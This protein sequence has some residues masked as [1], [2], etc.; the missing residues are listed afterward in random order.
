MLVAGQTTP[1]PGGGK[2]LEKMRFI[3]GDRASSICDGKRIN[4]GEIAEALH[5]L[6]ATESAV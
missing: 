5:Q 2:L 4:V 1:S 6:A 3:L